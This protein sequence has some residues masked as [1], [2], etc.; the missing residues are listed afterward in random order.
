MTSMFAST[1]LR[2]RPGLPQT[3]PVPIELYDAVTGRAARCVLQKFHLGALV[4]LGITFPSP[5]DL[6][7]RLCEWTWP[8]WMTFSLEAAKGLEAGRDL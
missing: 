6:W 2:A 8:V 7:R 4:I 1:P 3:L 5:A